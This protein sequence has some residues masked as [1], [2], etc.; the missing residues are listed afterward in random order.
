VPTRFSSGQRYRE[1]VLNGRKRVAIQFRPFSPRTLL[2]LSR[3]SCLAS[4][5]P[6]GDHQLTFPLPSASDFSFSVIGLPHRSM[7]RTALVTRL[8]PSFLPPLLSHPTQLSRGLLLNIHFA[9][10]LHASTT[11][12]SS[13]SQ[14]AMKPFRPTRHPSF[15]SGSAR[16]QWSRMSGGLP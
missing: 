13:P 9:V 8:L 14:R 3:P 11:Y 16:S 1:A 6:L 5:W 15:A 10:Q 2:P 4:P 7:S 12:T